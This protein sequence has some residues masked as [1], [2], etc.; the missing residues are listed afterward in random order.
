MRERAKEIERE[1]DEIASK[2]RVES[3]W[4]RGESRVNCTVENA[5]K[6]RVVEGKRRMTCGCVSQDRVAV[7]SRFCPASIGP[8]VSRLLGS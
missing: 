4:R 6:V 3:K 1:R 5:T 7:Y 2:T 8:F